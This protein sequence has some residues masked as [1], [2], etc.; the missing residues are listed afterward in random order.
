MK[1][2]NGNTPHAE[3]FCVALF[4]LCNSGKSSLL[5]AIVG[6]QVAIVSD[7]AGTTTDP[8][9]KAMELPDVGASL[10]IDTPGLDDNTLLGEMRVQRSREAIDRC[11]VAV[12]LFSDGVSDIEKNLIEELRRRETP[13]I[14]VI[15]KCDIKPNVQEFSHQI[16]L[17]T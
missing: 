14:A 6:Q 1:Y 15:S 2:D 12:I 17:T 10:I 9:S 8:I 13:I 11:D 7:I 5:N 3:R 16:T 4:G